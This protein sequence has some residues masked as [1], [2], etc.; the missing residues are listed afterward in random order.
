MTFTRS[1]DNTTPLGSAK[2][3]TIDDSLRNLKVDIDERLAEM[4]GIASINGVAQL[5]DGSTVKSLATL[6]TAVA[7][8]ATINAT[9]NT[10]PRRTAAGVLS[11]SGLTDNGTLITNTRHMGRTF[12]YLPAAWGDAIVAT[13]SATSLTAN[14]WMKL[15]LMTATEAHASAVTSS[16]WTPTAS[17]GYGAY[18]VTVSVNFGDTSGTATT[19]YNAIRIGDGSVWV[20]G[21]SELGNTSA[22]VIR[23]FTAVIV[24]QG[25]TAINLQIQGYQGTTTRNARVQSYSFIQLV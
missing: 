2:A 12:T 21:P 20:T 14:T 23:Q 7:N 16:V 6:T 22:T 4:T 5:V 18:L 9:N 17:Y 13:A 15:N 10:I 19:E 8:A 1:W 3:Y 11:D 24:N 25:S